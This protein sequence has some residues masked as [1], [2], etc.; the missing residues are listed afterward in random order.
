M[1]TKAEILLIAIAVL[2]FLFIIKQLKR[3]K[4][5]ERYAILWF[6]VGILVIALPIF[7]PIFDKLSHLIGIVYPP[8]LL[9]VSAILVL[10]IISL[11]YSIELTKLNKQNYVLAQKLAILENEIKKLEEKITKIAKKL[12]LD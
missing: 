3:K 5:D 12:Q 11:H 6:L 8:A 7:I 4:L 9:F 10:L 2:F 1:N